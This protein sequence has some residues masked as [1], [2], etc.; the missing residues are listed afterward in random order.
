MA[1][2]ALHESKT[3]REYNSSVLDVVGSRHASCI[4][5]PVLITRSLPDGNISSLQKGKREMMSP[6]YQSTPLAAACAGMVL[7][8]SVRDA[9]GNV[10]LAQDVVLTES[11][12]AALA[13]HGIATLHILHAAPAPKPVDPVAVQARLDHLFRDH[14]RDADAHCDRATGILRR[15]VEDYRLQR[16]I[17]P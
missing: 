14:A 17:A 6:S 11:M 8:D 10:L 9:K 1:I 13:R 7:A 3:R 2:N 12:L 5:D 15:Y 4:I 16:E